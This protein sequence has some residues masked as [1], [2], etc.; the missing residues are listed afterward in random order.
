MGSLK[1]HFFGDRPFPDTPGY[2]RPGTSQEA[3]RKVRGSANDRRAEALRLIIASPAGLTADEV[4]DAMLL[5]VLS[6]RPRVS[7]LVAQGRIIEG[8][9]RRKTSS[10]M[11]AAVWIPKPEAS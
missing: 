7:E 3:A 10:G 5:P 2:K 1:D 11:S 4:A 6:I 8:P 9:T